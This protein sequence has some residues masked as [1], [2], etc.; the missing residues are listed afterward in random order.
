M[1]GGSPEAGEA[2]QVVRSLIR[3]IKILPGL[4]APDGVWLETEGDP[5]VPPRAAAS[6][7]QAKTP[8]VVALGVLQVSV[9]AETRNRGS[10]YISVAI[11]RATK[12]TPVDSATLLPASVQRDCGRTRPQRGRR[13]MRTAET[14]ALD[15]NQAVEA[16]RSPLGES[17][18]AVGA[19][20]MSGGT[21]KS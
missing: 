21:R 2:L 1:G 11:R 16:A 19:A 20:C 14:S 5:A 3:G 18:A 4:A 7:E 10:Q 15:P 17:A 9:D 8:S 13:L 6:A 12:K